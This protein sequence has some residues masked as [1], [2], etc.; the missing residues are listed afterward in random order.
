MSTKFAFKFSVFELNYSFIT[1]T[2]F[3]E[4]IDR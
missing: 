4:N 1:E 2:Q 3:K